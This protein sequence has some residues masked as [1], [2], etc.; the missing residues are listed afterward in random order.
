MR[1]WNIG[2]AIPLSAYV[3]GQQHILHLLGCT[4]I[5]DCI[6]SFISF[7]SRHG[8]IV[9]ISSG[10][11]PWNCTLQPAFVDDGPGS[12]CRLKLKRTL[13]CVLVKGLED[14]CVL[15]VRYVLVVRKKHL[16]AASLR[17]VMSGYRLLDAFQIKQYYCCNA[18]QL[19]PGSECS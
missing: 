8:P 7:G 5:M 1:A 11:A 14:A 13:L 9:N 2:D 12:S 6:L 19:Q 4:G 18:F 10:A 3:V 17:V 16:L 15:V